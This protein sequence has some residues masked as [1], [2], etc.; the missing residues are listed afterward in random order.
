MQFIQMVMDFFRHIDLEKAFIFLFIVSLSAEW[1]ASRQRKKQTHQWRDSFTNFS[2]GAISLTFDFLFTLLMLPVWWY[3]FNHFRIFDFYT[4]TASTWLLLFVLVDFSEYW[5]HRLSHEI[6]LLWSAHVVHHQSEFFN[7]TVGLRTSLFVPLFN[8]F[9][10]SLFPLLGFDPEAVLAIIFVQGVYQLCI[11]TTFIKKLGWLEYVIVTPSAHRV[12]HGKNEIYIDKN[13]GKFFILWDQL[14]GTYQRE[15]EEVEFGITTPLAKKG[16]FYS[17]FEPFR[18]LVGLCRATKKRKQRW[19]VLFK[20]PDAVNE[21]IK[22]E[23]ITPAPRRRLLTYFRKPTVVLLILEHVFY[24][25][26]YA[27]IGGSGLATR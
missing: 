9:F 4:N 14:F 18:Y 3:A 19:F 16:V 25:M 6:N 20:T 26:L 1:L 13:Y 27:D 7:L 22:T 12:H 21:L 15:T 5:F 17:I 2:I 23:C 8:V 24:F 10:Y 11:H